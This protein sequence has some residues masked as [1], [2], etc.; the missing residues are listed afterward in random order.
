[1]S[2][3]NSAAGARRSPR[4]RRAALVA[5]LVA[6]MAAA[7]SGGAGPA[8]AQTA[9]AAPAADFAPAALWRG[10]A[11]AGP[12][13]PAS[14]VA[15]VFAMDRRPRYESSFICL[16]GGWRFERDG[17][18]AS[19]V[20]LPPGEH[21]LGLLYQSS[22][23]TGMGA[24]RIRVQAGRVYQVNVS[25]LRTQGRGVVEVWPMAPGHVLTW[26]NLAPGQAAGSARIDEAVPV[27]QTQAGDPL[28]P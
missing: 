21:D 24:V 9:S 13:R 22:T 19:V 16:A 28:T 5:A 26:R 17:R 1:M 4:G 11:Y 2:A 3:P 25:S 10:Q 23:E 6:V 8:G 14:E 20:Y 15:T 7:L 18:C 12:A 27:G